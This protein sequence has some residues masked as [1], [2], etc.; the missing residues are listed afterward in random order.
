M[1]GITSTDY[2]SQIDLIIP[3][4]LEQITQYCRND[5]ILKSNGLYIYDDTDLTITSNTITLNTDLPFITGDFF[6]LYGTTYN[7]NLFQ[8]NDFSSGVITIESSKTMRTETAASTIIALVDFPSVFL[9]II[10]SYINSDIVNDGN[11]KKE[12]IKDTEIEYFG[13]SSGTGY[14]NNDFIE[15]NKKFLNPYKKVYKESFK[16]LFE[17]C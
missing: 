6:R 12:K 9:D 15:Q 4:L 11:I 14:S 5:F 3:Q 10:G 17:F 1:L 2:D 7:D 16:K 13:S 8:V